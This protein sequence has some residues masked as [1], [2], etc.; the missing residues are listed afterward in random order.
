MSNDQQ[1]TRVSLTNP[2]HHQVTGIPAIFLSELRNNPLCVP[3][4]FVHQ[5]GSWDPWVAVS[6]LSGFGGLGSTPPWQQSQRNSCSGEAFAEGE[7]VK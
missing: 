7:G 3:L 6:G 1:Q 4:S 2:N 5:H